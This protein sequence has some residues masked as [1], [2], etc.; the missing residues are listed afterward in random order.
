MNALVL[1]GGGARGAHTAGA[2]RCLAEKGVFD[3]VGIASGTSIGAANAVGIAHYPRLSDGAR[4]LLDCWHDLAG[5]KSVWR[6]RQPKGIPGL[7][8]PSFG[9][10]S[11]IREFL[12]RTIKPDLIS[13]SGV[14]LR[15]PTVNLCTGELAVLTEAYQPLWKAVYA[16]ASFPGMFEPIELTNPPGWY[17]DGGT[18]DIA[19]L[20]AAID[21][22]ANRIIVITTRKP[23]AL[24]PKARGELETA[25]RVLLRCVEIMIDEILLADLRVC[26]RTN[27][28]AD[29]TGKKRVELLHIYPSED[30]GDSLDFSKDL[31]EK[32]LELGYRDAEKAIWERWKQ[33]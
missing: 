10:A 22:G 5:T 32:R 9:E 15:F 14:K 4:Y 7:W 3:R 12:K 33:S 11:E 20:G 29:L 26:E 19:P 18:R 27:K 31:T 8:N 24:L 1:S 16:S 6:W 21:A 25:P 28:T 17:T 2:I 23:G 30:L 13:I